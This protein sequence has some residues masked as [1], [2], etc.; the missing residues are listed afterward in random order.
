MEKLQRKMEG[1][2][3]IVDGARP[4]VSNLCTSEVI[5]KVIIQGQGQLKVISRS[6]QGHIMWVTVNQIRSNFALFDQTF[7]V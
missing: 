1:L 5:V 3:N 6:S 7:G 2:T 4:G